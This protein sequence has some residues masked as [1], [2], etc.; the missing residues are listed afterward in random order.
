MTPFATTSSYVS[1]P[2]FS[3]TSKQKHLV[4]APCT[5]TDAVAFHKFGRREKWRSNVVVSGSCF[6]VQFL[7]S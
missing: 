3:K 7:K 6:S 2:S 1:S 5:E 4:L